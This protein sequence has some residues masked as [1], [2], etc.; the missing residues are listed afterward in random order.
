M[1]KTEKPPRL[2][3]LG[4]RG[5]KVKSIKSIKSIKTMQ[6]HTEQCSHAFTLWR[7]CFFGVSVF[8]FVGF[9]PPPYKYDF[10]GGFQ[11]EY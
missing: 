8:R 5:E 4:A 9:S 3:V 1:V 6:T 11:S 2:F 10:S 7:I